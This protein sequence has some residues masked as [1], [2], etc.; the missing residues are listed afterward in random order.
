MIVAAHGNVSEYCA[1]H[2]MQIGE[3]YTGKVED[4]HGNCLILVTDNC[5]TEHEYYYLKYKLRKRKIELVSTHWNNEDV[6]A[7]VRYLEQMES[8]EKSGGR[9][10]FGFR[11]ESGKVVEDPAVIEVARKVIALRDAGIP[12]RKIAESDEICYRDGSKLSIST[13]QVI[14]KNRSKYDEK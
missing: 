2:G 12:W 4:Y 11:W 8:R 1:A 9:A 7:F 6:S 5:D 10:P 14:V 3:V 13:L